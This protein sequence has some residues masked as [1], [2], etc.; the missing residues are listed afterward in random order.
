MLSAV[1]KHWTALK[2]SNIDVLRSE[3]L[4]REGKIS[5][6]KDKTNLFVQR[7]T[8]DVLLEKLPWSLSFFKLPW[9]KHM[10]SLEW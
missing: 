1:L 9:I 7:K 5:I 2:S 4:M 10:T 6:K 8:Q 3:F